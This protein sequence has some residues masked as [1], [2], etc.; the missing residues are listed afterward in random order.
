MQTLLDFFTLSSQLV[1]ATRVRVP[2][3]PDP[4]GFMA[5]RRDSITLIAPTVAGPLLAVAGS[6]GPTT[7]RDVAFLLDDGV[8]R[9]QVEVTA[10]LRLS[11]HLRQHGPYI[12]L[13]HGMLAPY[14]GTLQS[15]GWRVAT[16]RSTESRSTWPSRPVTFPV[17][18]EP[19]LAGAGWRCRGAKSLIHAGGRWPASGLGG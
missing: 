6:H 16:L 18:N 15:S 5:L 13:R 12:V 3:E 11:D 8:L 4:L 1:T 14:G 17:T 9:G 7:T 10:N 2:Q 19:A